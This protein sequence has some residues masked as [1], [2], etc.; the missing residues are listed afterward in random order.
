MG[1]RGRVLGEWWARRDTCGERVGSCLRR[2]DGRGAGMTEGAARVIGAQRDL[3][4]W[5]VASH[6]P[7]H[8][9]LGRGEG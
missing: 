3:V 8:L 4:R 5:L 9:H 7:P 2:N 1:K 6:P